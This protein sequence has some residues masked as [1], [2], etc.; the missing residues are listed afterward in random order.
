[1]GV[2]NSTAN[3]REK[4]D[5]D[6]QRVIREYF[7]GKEYESDSKYFNL[8]PIEK[9]VLWNGKKMYTQ[10]KTKYFGEDSDG[11]KY[12]SDYI[13]FL[14]D[15]T[16]VPVGKLCY[17]LDIFCRQ[18]F[19]VRLDSNEYDVNGSKL[20]QPI[21]TGFVFFQRYSDDYIYYT[22]ARLNRTESHSLSGGYIF[23]SDQEGEHCNVIYKRL[24]TLYEGGKVL[25]NYNSIQF[26]KYDE[27]DSRW[28]IQL[29]ETN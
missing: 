1:M 17:G 19:V 10:H 23:N 13:D 20:G 7:L 11:E 26:D 8:T 3:P 6:T 29:E 18:F 24:K 12:A 9:G 14:L 5:P 16:D 4:S 15:V 25:S 22:S 28:E 2:G 21:R 27:T